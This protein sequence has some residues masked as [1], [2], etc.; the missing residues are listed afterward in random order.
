[1]KLEASVADTQLRDV[2]GA[3]ALCEKKAL[4]SLDLVW[5]G[6]LGGAV[7]PLAGRE[8]LRCGSALTREPRGGRF[9]S[10]S[11]VQLRGCTTET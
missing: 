4:G 9:L 6:Q 5:L 1:M 8:W 3:F 10:P 2:P 11:H 7:F